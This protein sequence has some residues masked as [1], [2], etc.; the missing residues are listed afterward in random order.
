MMMSIDQF[1]FSLT[2][3]PYKELQRQRNWKHAKSTRVGTRDASQFTGAGDDTITLNGMVAE[4]NS[5]GTAA[6]IDQLAKMGDKG[7]AYVLVAG[8]GEVFGAF[9]IESLNTTATY[10]RAD[11]VARKIEFNLTIQR[12][13]DTAMSTAAATA[14]AAKK[15]AAQQTASKAS[16]VLAD[17]QKAAT[18]ARSIYNAAKAVN[19]ADAFSAASSIVGGIDTVAATVG[20]KG[21]SAASGLPIAAAI[22]GAKD[23]ATLTKQPLSSIVNNV[24]NRVAGS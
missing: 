13:D 21:L 2:T 8:S 5:I 14:A 22:N 19:T 11:G 20:V 24:L 23:V 18:I 17:V 7:D 9:V 4:D 3:A 16:Q 1:V 10:L 6:S 12:V 15:A